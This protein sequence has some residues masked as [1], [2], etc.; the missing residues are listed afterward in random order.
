M[1]EIYDVVVVG[2][3]LCGSCCGALH[4]KAW[5]KHTCGD[6]RDRRKGSN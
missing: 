6:K 3:G 4:L 1:V 5:I 2:V